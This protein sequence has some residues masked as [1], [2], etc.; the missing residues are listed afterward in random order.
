MKKNIEPVG[1]DVSYEDGEFKLP[2]N[3]SD[4]YLYVIEIVGIGVKFGIT[5]NPKCRISS[6]SRNAKAHHS[7]LGRI[8][9]S[10]PHKNYSNNE[11]IL[12]E[13]LHTKREYVNEEYET[14]MK[15]ASGL[16]KTPGEP[17]DT[18]SHDAIT[19]FVNKYCEMRDD[20][21]RAKADRLFLGYASKNVMRMMTNLYLFLLDSD[22]TPDQINELA[23]NGPYNVHD[24]DN[25]TE[26]EIN[27]FIE[28]LIRK[29]K[30]EMQGKPGTNYFNNGL[31]KIKET[32]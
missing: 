12:R 14:V 20:L 28:L 31:N 29:A 15:L 1:F 25:D 23:T 8:W 7:Q 19:D 24:N 22:F 9:L 30:Q 16:T 2:N 11:N 32:K 26:E 18:S 13:K 17:N 10:I 27:E 4:G 6:H 3:E 5:R 21:A